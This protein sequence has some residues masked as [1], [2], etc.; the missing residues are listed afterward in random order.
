MLFQR[1]P[2]SCSWKPCKYPF[3]LLDNLVWQLLLRLIRRIGRTRGTVVL[4]LDFYCRPSMLSLTLDLRWRRVFMFEIHFHGMREVS[5]GVFDQPPLVD[6]VDLDLE[7]SCCGARGAVVFVL[8]LQVEP[9]GWVRRGWG[10]VLVRGGNGVRGSW[11][12]AFQEGCVVVSWGVVKLI[13]TLGRN[14]E[15]SS[16]FRLGFM[17]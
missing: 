2:I 9:R 7:R 17:F 8:P 3:A 10:V 15:S 12:P 5:S 11:L 16:G 4:M 14:V 13:V 1:L 6:L